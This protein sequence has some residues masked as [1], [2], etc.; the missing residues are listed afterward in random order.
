MTEELKNQYI[1]DYLNKLAEDYPQLINTEK[2]QKAKDMFLNRSE[3]YEEIIEEINKIIQDMIEKENQRIEMRNKLAEQIKKK[4]A[5]ALDKEKF[6]GET[7]KSSLIEIFKLY[8]SINNQDITDN[9]KH[10]IFEQELEKFISASKIETLEYLKRLTNNPEL[11]ES[12]LSASYIGY[13]SLNYDNVGQLRDIFINDFDVIQCESEGKM[14]MTVPAD[15]RIFDDNGNINPDLEFDFSRI[16]TIYDYA[17]EHGKQ[18]KHH[19]LLWHNSVPENL[20]I[21]LEKINDPSKRR[22]MSLKFLDYYYGK[23]ADVLKEYDIRQIDAL[24]EIASD[25]MTSSDTYRQSFWRDMIGNNPINGDEY[26]IDVL[27]IIRKN[28]PDTELIYNDYNEFYEGKC[29]RMCEII[30]YIQSREHDGEKLIDG[31]GLQAHYRDFLPGLDRMLTP[32]DIERTALKFAE[33]GIPIY[34]T[35]FDFINT[36]NS[37]I[38]KLLETFT[39][40]Y[41]NIASGFNTWGNSDEL[42]WYH[43]LGPDGKTLNP[44]IIDANGNKKEIFNILKEKFNSKI[45][46]FNYDKQFEI[47]K[48]TESELPKVTEYFTQMLMRL[49]HNTLENLNLLYANKKWE[50]IKNMNPK[51]LTKEEIELQ[52][53]KRMEVGKKIIENMLKERYGTDIKIDSPEYKS[54]IQ[55][56]EKL[57]KSNPNS[58]FNIVENYKKNIKKAYSRISDSVQV[59]LPTQGLHQINATQ[60]RENQYLNGIETG[61][62][63]TSGAG[64]LDYIVRTNTGS[65]HGD[66]QNLDLP[67]NPFNKEKTTDKR[68]ALNKTASI[69]HLKVEHFEPVVD[70]KLDSDGKPSLRFGQEWV[71]KKSYLPCEE[72][73]TDYVPRSYVDKKNIT[74]QGKSLKENMPEKNITQEKVSVSHKK[75]FDQRSQTEIQ[76]HQQIK[77]KNQAIKQQKAQKQQL[78]KPKV[79]TLSAPSSQ[80]N[81]SSSNK[82]Y[83]NIILLSLIVSFVCGALFMVVYMIIGR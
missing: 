70:F 38:S 62:Y 45:K 25:D 22:Y 39:N 27:R 76:V 73:R 44:H 40:T 49:P 28:F 57:E 78:N 24:N 83:T 13:D 77:E 82:G 35:E 61:I 50:T 4:Q 65:M 1:E 69:Y 59:A 72:K 53:Q 31:L 58:A 3:S 60:N 7:Y 15:Q 79:K 46:D 37:D 56:V 26:F 18:I 23:L 2:L 51:G 80:G 17:K 10:T 33:L 29:D 32:E 66:G 64:I 71:A 11:I 67:N 36:K 34:I 14:K 68:V 48:N 12:G 21:E 43:C 74:I 55:N 8:E 54:I 16:K 75:S 41:G 19:E 20:R 81:G 30:K 9:E 52:R 6:F 47:I 42:T 63:A 5:E